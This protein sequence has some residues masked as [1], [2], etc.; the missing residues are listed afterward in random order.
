MSYMSII[1]IEIVDIKT[2]YAINHR[3]YA[4]RYYGTYSS[5]VYTFEYI[6][7]PILENSDLVDFN[8]FFSQ[9]YINILYKLN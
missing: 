2:V 8:I 1:V 7:K 5:R 9:D 6:E 4:S 3:E